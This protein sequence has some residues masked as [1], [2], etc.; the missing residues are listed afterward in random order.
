MIARTTR[1]LFIALL[2]AGI[3]L[4]GTAG[5]AAAA[6]PGS[7]PLRITAT[8][9]TY[10]QPDLTGFRRAATTITITNNTR[11]TID[12]PTITFPVN[13]R[14]GALHTEWSGCPRG[15]GRPDAVYCV[16]E[17]L[18]AGEKRDLVFPFGTDKAGPTGPARARADVASDPLGT[19]VPG[20]RTFATW[21]VRFAPLT[22]TFGIATEDMNFGER[23][24]Q[25]ARHAVL[26]VTLT[27]LTD[28]PIGF[29]TLTF[30][31]GSG[32]PDTATWLG[33]V[34]TYPQPNEATACVTKPLSAGERRTMTFAFS[35]V[36]FM[37][38]HPDT[39]T[40]A[41]ATSAEPGAPMLP[42]TTAGSTYN[43]NSPDDNA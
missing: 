7:F 16:T 28:Q 34:A 18:A 2:G 17:P 1:R 4:A 24:A 32:T 19:P 37:F 13:D 29:P 30:A 43:V 12:Y 39:L 26:K 15:G 25:G 33:C 36:D 27:N 9:M 5:A 41:A 6:P 10:G 21:Q 14:D 38:S 23:D 22:G 31:P 35:L 42:D 3:A 8:N 20:T 11:H 40:V